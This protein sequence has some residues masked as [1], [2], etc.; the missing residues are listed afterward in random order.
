[1]TV[2]TEAVQGGYGSPPTAGLTSRSHQE[3][4]R[5]PQGNQG[6]R[7]HRLWPRTAWGWP[8]IGRSSGGPAGE[9]S[10]SQ[11]AKI[12]GLCLR[13]A[14]IKE[15]AASKPRMAKAAHG[16]RQRRHKKAS[17]L[18]KRVRNVSCAAA[19]AHFQEQRRCMS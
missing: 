19:I 16:H 8:E 9:S 13:E 7:H 17:E 10:S 12:V 15:K 18:Y 2:R 14:V 3:L 11:Q 5:A 1:M 4:I 6:H